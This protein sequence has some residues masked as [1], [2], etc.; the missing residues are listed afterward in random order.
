[1][2]NGLMPWGNHR[3]LPLGPMREPLTALGR[4][5]IVVVHH[6]DL[7]SEQALDNI[8][9]T[10][11]EIK[12]S[13]HIFYSRMAASHF[14][15]VK[16]TPISMP[17]TAAVNKVLLCVSAIG[18]PN[19]FVKCIEKLGPLHVD[20][21]DFSDHYLFQ[22]KDIYMIKVKAQNLED[23]FGLK[24]AIVVTEKDY[25]RHQGILLHLHPFDVF[26]LCS[27]LRFEPRRGCSEDSF[28][29]LLVQLLGVRDHRLSI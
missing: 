14:L 1:M 6:A 21:I 22:A 11:R 8:E 7:V 5:N 24:P 10:V 19:A 27:R 4:A 15:L 9:S 13:L 16:N 28:K 18:S 12:E 26:V 2:I 20:R 25:D 3:L 17:L 29:K 23:R